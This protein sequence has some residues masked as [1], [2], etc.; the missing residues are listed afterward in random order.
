M[1]TGKL[2]LAGLL[3]WATGGGMVAL[4]GWA[5]YVDKLK[6]SVSEPEEATS[7]VSL[8]D[9]EMVSGLKEAL[10][11]GTQFAVDSLGRDGGFLDN[12]MVKIPMPESL[13]WVEK[14]LRTMRQ[15]E[16]ADEFI[17]T[18]NHAAEQAVP[19]AAA[20]FGD[21]IQ[22]MSV[23]DARGILTGPDDAA[24]QYFRTNTEAAL[25]GKMRPIVEQATARTGVTS[26]YKNM[27]AQAGGLTGMLSSDA[28]DLDGYVTGKTLDGLFLMIAEEEKKIRENP[29]ARSTDL[30]KKVF[31]AYQ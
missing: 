3:V 11:K 12:S 19:E 27:T 29:L 20:I 7:G 14:S 18:M 4:A 13:S 5:D 23:E 10:G 28:T 1:K 25:T 15:D 17:A 24:T 6:G 9:T 8:T 26:A 31:G 2:L 30:L 16:L 21:A 22:Q